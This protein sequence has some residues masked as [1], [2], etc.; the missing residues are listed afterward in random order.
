VGPIE[1]SLRQA[2]GAIQIGIGQIRIVE[3]CQ[4]EIRTAQICTAQRG[5]DQ[6][7]GAQPCVAEVGPVEPRIA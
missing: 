1:L 2:F 7:C 4:A 3:P 5:P 6:E